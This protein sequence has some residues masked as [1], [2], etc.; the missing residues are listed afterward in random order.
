MLTA[1]ATPTAIRNAGKPAVEPPDDPRPPRSSAARRRASRPCVAGTWATVWVSSRTV[2]SWASM[3]HAEQAVE[4]AHD[5]DHRGARHVPDEERP[6]QVA[7]DEPE[8]GQAGQDQQD[9][10]EQRERGG[11]GEVP[12]RVADGQRRDRPTRSAARSSPPARRSSRAR[13]PNRAYPT[14]APIE[15]YR[16]D[17]RI[18]PGQLRVRERLRDQQRPD[19]QAG[20]EVR[21]EPGPVVGPQPDQPRDRLEDAHGQATVM[22]SSGRS[23]NGGRA[24]ARFENGST[25]G[26]R[27]IP[28]ASA[29]NRRR[30]SM[31]AQASG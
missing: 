2:S 8:P 16:P 4:L 23:R 19:G 24:A 29:M 22:T 7:G 3:R 26:W 11:E 10:G 17:D 21:S 31:R 12:A 27:S 20:E 30:A 13:R 25:S 6:A 18:Q 14:I 5:H 28:R 9:P 1:S 15:A